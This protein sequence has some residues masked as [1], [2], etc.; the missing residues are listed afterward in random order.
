MSSSGIPAWRK[1]S[2][3]SI[4]V[5]KETVHPERTDPIPRIG[6][7]KLWVCSHV[8]Q[9]LSLSVLVPTLSGWSFTDTIVG[10]GS[11]DDPQVVLVCSL[12]WELAVFG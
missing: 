1:Q 2:P 4:L 6:S 7:G 10:F 8:T 12:V 3:L 5:L 11:L 9:P